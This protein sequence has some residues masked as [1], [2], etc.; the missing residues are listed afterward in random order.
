LNRQ[1]IKIRFATTLI[2]NI[3]HVGFSFVTGLVIA[4]SLGPKDYGNFNFL[5]GSFAAIMSFADMASSSAFYTL[6]SQKQRG[7]KFFL[8]YAGW[9]AIQI[10]LIFLFIFLMPDSLRQKIWLGQPL[11]LILLAFVV[12]LST[13][14]VWRVAGQIGESIRD[15]LGVQIR[16]FALSVFYLFV[17]LILAY[18]QI[19][20]IRNLLFV[21]IVLYL[22]FSLFYFYRL[23][24]AE[25]LI[26]KD[27][28]KIEAVFGEFK[29]FCLPMI[30]FTAIGFLYSFAD[31]WLLQRFGGAVQQGY[32]SIGARFA[33][34]SLIATTSILQIFWKEI[35]EAYSLAN[36]ER[37]R[38]LYSRVSKS[39][40]YRGFNQLYFNTFQ[41]RNINFASWDGL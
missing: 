7:K 24:C 2:T 26:T 10:F 20:S 11:D 25:N 27:D 36:L 23:F 3:L 28:E 39:L 15:T 31:Y 37:V 34:L 32:Y 41:Q 16:N 17:V 13:N 6:I 19:V 4:R 38:A 1:S 14:M 9:L 12:T 18:F 30:V 33:A 40:F 21:N 8:Y 35:A 5:L 29:K 22:L